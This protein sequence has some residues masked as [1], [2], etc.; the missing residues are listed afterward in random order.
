MPLTTARNKQK[1]KKNK[2]Q[3]K[4]GFYAQIVQDP[5]G[6]SV[7]NWKSTFY[8]WMPFLIIRSEERSLFIYTDFCCNNAMYAMLK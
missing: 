7:N 6:C 1:P 3:G 8:G 5:V 4:Y 2:F